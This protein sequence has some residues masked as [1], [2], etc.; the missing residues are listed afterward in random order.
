VTEP[1]LRPRRPSIGAMMTD[2]TVIRE[3][4]PLTGRGTN[5]R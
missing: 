5:Y 1:N 3:Q 4:R 2:L